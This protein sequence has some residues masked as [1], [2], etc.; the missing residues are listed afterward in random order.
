MGETCDDIN[1]YCNRECCENFD[2]DDWN[3]EFDD[4][5]RCAVIAAI[6]GVSLLI[7]LLTYF[8]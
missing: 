5:E 8:K 7:A 1:C 3:F 2:D 6:I 4:K